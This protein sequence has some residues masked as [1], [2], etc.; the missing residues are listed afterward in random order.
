MRKLSL[1]AALVA[2][3]LGLAPRAHATQT[4]SLGMAGFAFPLSETE[5]CWQHAWGS[6]SLTS[7]C[8][9]GSHTWV[10]PMA[11]P[12]SASNQTLSG[13]ITAYFP[14][15]NDQACFQA[16]SVD[17]RTV[18]YATTSMN[19]YQGAPGSYGAKNIDTFIVPSGGAAYLNYSTT[20]N[21]FWNGASLNT[22]R[23]GS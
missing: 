22:V 17:Y 13:V 6:I 19:C 11:V 1:I 8:A 23:W 3:A 14:T 20:K 9:W 7:S 18:V 12:Y 4:V 21:G 16:T 5:S 10:V 2:A 15:I